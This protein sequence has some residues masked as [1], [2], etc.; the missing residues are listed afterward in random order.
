VLYTSILD[1]N[2]VLAGFDSNP[3]G[4]GQDVINLDALF[5]SYGALS[6]TRADH[7]SIVQSGSD[8]VVQVDTNNTVGTYEMTITLTGVTAS[9]VT[10]GSDVLLG[11]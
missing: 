2:D 3:N 6:G 7:V 9:T 8:T 5:D 11:S 10:I 4:G 1:G